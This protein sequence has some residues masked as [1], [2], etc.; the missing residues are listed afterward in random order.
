M[1]TPFFTVLHALCNPY[2]FCFTW[3]RCPS[4]AFSLLRFLTASQVPSYHG[5]AVNFTKPHDV[6]PKDTVFGQFGSLCSFHGL[7]REC[8]MNILPRSVAI[9]LPFSCPH[10]ESASMFSAEKHSFALS[11]KNICSVPPF[12]EQLSFFFLFP[13]TAC[14]VVFSLRGA[15]LQLF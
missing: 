12:S 13:P 14:R 9:A 3:P 1:F 4:L 10:V 5:A 2:G 11:I 6:S 7:R 15:R 8:V